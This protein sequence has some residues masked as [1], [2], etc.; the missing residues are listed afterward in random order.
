MLSR[1]IPSSDNDGR[2][3]RLSSHSPNS[4]SHCCALNCS[5]ATCGAAEMMR[6]TAWRKR[7]STDTPWAFACAKSAASSSVVKG[8]GTVTDIRYAPVYIVPNRFCM[9]NP[10]PNRQPRQEQ[11]VR[12]DVFPIRNRTALHLPAMFPQLALQLFSAEPLL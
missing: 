5:G 6:R 11:S 4:F 2:L 12:R 10:L 1:L 3:G 7:E 8:T 9:N